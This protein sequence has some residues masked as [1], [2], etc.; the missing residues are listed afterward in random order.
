MIS[1]D[2]IVA[3]VEQGIERKKQSGQWYHENVIYDHDWLLEESGKAQLDVIWNL[4]GLSGGRKQAQKRQAFYTFVANLMYAKYRG[5]PLSVSLDT[6]KQ[7]R[8]IIK[9]VRLFHKH[10]LIEIKKGHNIQPNPRMTRI[11]AT[12]LLLKYCEELPNM[13][14]W[15]PKQLVI[16]KDENGNEKEY[17]AT[18]YTRQLHKE[19]KQ[20][21][22]VNTLAEIF[23]GKRKISVFIRAIHKGKF[24][25][26]GRLY[27][28]GYSHL[29]QAQGLKKEERRE[30]II[31]NDLVI[32]WDYGAIGPM[33]L[34]AQEGIQY[35]GDPY[36]VVDDREELRPLLKHIVQCMFNNKG[37]TK[38]EAASNNW[39][40][41]EGDKTKTTPIH[42][43]GITK[44]RPFMDALIEKHEPIEKY[45][46]QGNDIGLQLQN[47]DGKI[48]R[49][50]IK[51][52]IKQ[53]IPIIPV[54]DS[55]IVQQQHKQELYEVMLS[56]YQNHSGG[57]SIEINPQK[58]TGTEYEDFYL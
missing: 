41:V 25:M 32:E 45:F 38:A 4:L 9:L 27:T 13:I 29:I 55:F 2:A 52:F 8:F 34:Y 40:N 48:A 23:F 28:K 44:V 20:A 36:T 57:F 26:G 10:G 56:V 12:D 31:N 49:D 14:A 19:L 11:T 35:E 58:V 51:H 1:S 3:N 53:G 43:L 47:K 5:K 54:H 15:V 22:D 37:Y 16:L 18:A 21:N 42:K 6:A 30:L 17:T 24:T 50:V 39:L 7:S 46:F 33:L